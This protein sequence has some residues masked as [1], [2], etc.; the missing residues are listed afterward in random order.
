MSSTLVSWRSSAGSRRR[1]WSHCHQSPWLGLLGTIHCT[2]EMPRVRPPWTTCLLEGMAPSE[3]LWLWPDQPGSYL[4]TCLVGAALWPAPPHQRGLGPGQSSFIN[5]IFLWGIRF[6]LADSL[7]CDNCGFLNLSASWMFLSTS[8]KFSFDIVGTCLVFFFHSTFK[9]CLAVA[10]QVAYIWARMRRDVETG[11]GGSVNGHPP[12]WGIHRLCK[13]N[14][15]FI[16][17]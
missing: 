15:T 13:N 14:S 2:E 8:L 4:A 3:S 10:E 6:Y 1:P 11:S 7:T 16:F 17:H 5:T 12:E 9:A